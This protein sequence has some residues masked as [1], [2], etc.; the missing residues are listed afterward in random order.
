MTS[1][2]SNAG[3]HEHHRFQA[4]HFDTGEQQ[5]QAGKLGMWLFLSTEVLF[6]S[7]MFCAYAV[8]RMNH[9]DLF[10]FAHTFLNPY[11]GAANTLVLLASSLSVAW[12][13]RCAQLG[14]RLALLV[15]LVFTLACAGVFMGVKTVEYGLKIHEGLLWG[16]MYSHVKDSHPDLTL[17]HSQLHQIGLSACGFGVAFVLL[18]LLA[19]AKMQSFRGICFALFPTAILAGVV[20]LFA[21][22]RMS[23]APAYLTTTFVYSIPVGF[24]LLVLGLILLG[25]VRGARWGLL[26]VGATLLGIAGGCLAANAYTLHEESKVDHGHSETAELHHAEGHE[27]EDHK[28]ETH[29]AET[30]EVETHELASVKGALFT[31][32]EPLYGGRGDNFPGVF[33]S[34]YYAMTGVHALHIFGGIGV[35]IWIVYRAGAAHFTPDYYGPVEY[36][37][38]YWHLVDLIWIFLFPLL[39]L[40][41]TTH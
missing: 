36:V 23:D 20:C 27:S 11:L 33:F 13:V 8:Y 2:T 32:T 38:L 19:S 24:S 18:G 37:A 39:Y 6:F 31:E 29:E 28:P 7:G 1:N 26:A 15:N 3:Q 25:E 21:G 16:S 4:H 41:Q 9:P 34:I 17:A 5:F 35:F 40:I 12:A 30:H 22:M 14:Q 10:E